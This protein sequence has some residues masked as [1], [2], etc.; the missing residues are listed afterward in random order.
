MAKV[1]DLHTV[2]GIMGFKMKTW[3]LAR[4]RG[5]S[6]RKIEKFIAWVLTDYDSA[7]LITDL[8]LDFEDKEG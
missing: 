2:D 8:M 5:W 1:Y 6:Q 3:T 7:E 4:A